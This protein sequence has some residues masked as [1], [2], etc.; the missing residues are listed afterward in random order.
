MTPPKQSEWTVQRHTKRQFAAA[1]WPPSKRVLV[2]VMPVCLDFLQWR[3]FLIAF[4][5]SRAGVLFLFLHFD[6]ATLKFFLP[7]VLFCC[8]I[9][10]PNQGHSN[11]G[12]SFDLKMT[13]LF[14][15]HIWP[16][17]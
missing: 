4:S 14:Q 11:G 5:V 13:M 6:G 16:Q 3:M 8:K 7:P 2:E 1:L 15:G 17:T 10:L 9:G 12:L